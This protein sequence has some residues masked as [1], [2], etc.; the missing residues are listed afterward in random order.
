MVESSHRATVL[1]FKGVA[2]NIA[3]GSVGLLF[4]ALMRYVRSGV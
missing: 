3:Y 4:A 1:S 2:M